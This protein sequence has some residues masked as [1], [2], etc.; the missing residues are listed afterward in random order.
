MLFAS[1]LWAMAPTLHSELPLATNRNG[2]SEGA[3]LTRDGRQ[4]FHEKS[5]RIFREVRMKRRP[6]VHDLS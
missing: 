1:A 2:I 6:H 5:R 4:P 3:F